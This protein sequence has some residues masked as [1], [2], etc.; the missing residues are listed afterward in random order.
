MGMMLRAALIL[1][2][3]ATIVLVAMSARG[4][5]LAQQLT[6]KDPEPLTTGRAHRLCRRWRVRERGTA[7]RRSMPPATG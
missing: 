5:A 4:S 6:A 3:V 2:S 7:A 1:A